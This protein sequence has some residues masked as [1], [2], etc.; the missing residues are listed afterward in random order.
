M[1][2]NNYELKDLKNRRI[3]VTGASGFHGSWLTQ[4]LL[5]QGASVTTILA[6]WNPESYFVTSGA[7]NHVKCAV[8]Q[9]ENYE[10]VERVI[11]ENKIEAVFH[12]AAIALE[13]A[14]YQS[15]LQA[16]E[17]N[18]RGTYNVLEAC[19]RSGQVSRVVVA[20]S[21]KVYGDSPAL[22]YTERMP[23]LGI[24]PY[25][26]SKVCEDLL[27]QSFYHSYGLPVIIGRFGNIYGGGD[28]AWSRLIPG[29]I[30]RLLNEEAPVVRVP[31]EG[32]SFKRDFLY[33]K[34]LVGAY[35]AMFWGLD[36]PQ[37]HGQAFNFA[38]GGSWTVLEIVQK[39]QALL[40]REHIEP[41]I[42][43]K[44]HTEI[45]SQHMSFN[46]AQQMLHWLPRYSLE[47]GLQETVAW[48]CDFFA[49]HPHYI[50]PSVYSI[51]LPAAV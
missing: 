21:D 34:D 46:K 42:V 33:V 20:S 36:H 35:L 13:G 6:D 39:L 32:G 30:R 3:L 24:N 1:S 51:L 15:P 16:F 23:L 7:I 25:D 48:Y 26:V 31:K 27:A 45:L 44:E 38:L 47:Q 10:L 49:R 41:Q 37:T 12:L 14:A 4:H 28:L 5:D 29:T 19:R 22:P 9:I 11:V 18:I 8:G 2:T 43:L 50:N 17:V 40:G